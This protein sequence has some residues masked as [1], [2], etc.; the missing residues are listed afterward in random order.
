MVPLRIHTIQ[1]A[2]IDRP[3]ILSDQGVTEQPRAPNPNCAFL[4][5]LSL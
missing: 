1:F 5:G 2:Q 4:G 3:I